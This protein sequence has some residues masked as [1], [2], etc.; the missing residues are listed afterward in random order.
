MVERAAS[1]ARTE[2]S[3]QHIFSKILVP[4]D[5]T[6]ESAAVL[7]PARAR[8]AATGAA[9]TLLTVVDTDTPAA[10]QEAAATE[11]A[12]A[13]QALGT[14][15][16]GARMLVRRGEPAA[17]IA[18]AVGEEGADL[19]AMATHGRNG[20]A[21]AFLGSV[22]ERVLAVSPVPVLLLRPGGEPK[23]EMSRLEKILV[24]VDGSAGGALALAHAVPLA[25]AAG[26]RIVL[27]EVAVSLV[28]ATVLAGAMASAAAYGGQF[29]FD[30][31]WDEE[32]LERAR[33]H[34]TRLADR[35]RQSGVETEGRAVLGTAERQ[36]TVVADAL[37]QTADDVSADLIAMSTHALTGPARA[38]LGS[39]ADAVVRSSYRPVLLVRR[40]RSESDATPP[41][42]GETPGV[43][44]PG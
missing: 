22:A 23:H 39:V 34:V 1:A 40:P 43:R 9:L 11:L 20:L 3:T 5:G 12:R 25:R 37:T 38:V 8:A 28:S 42:D 44:Q 41:A 26:A 33:N 29:Y 4:L 35:V 19:V 31:T 15:G 24:P 17:E 2:R 16:E 30:P 13:N 18:W 10:R 7:G 21:R 36:S 14:E 27:V 32:S 6:A